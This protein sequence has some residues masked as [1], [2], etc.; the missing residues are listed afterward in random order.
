MHYVDWHCSVMYVRV[1]LPQ[2]LCKFCECTG[3][4]FILCLVLATLVTFLSIML[5]PWLWRSLTLEILDLGFVPVA[6]TVW[7]SPCNCTVFVVAVLMRWWWRCY[8]ARRQKT[9]IVRRASSHSQ[10]NTLCIIIIIIIINVCC[11][12]CRT[13][14]KTSRALNKKKN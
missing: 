5:W 12:E 3:L 7:S 9:R 1:S 14:K 10:C 8:K 2:H 13:V 11:W 6:L 4:G